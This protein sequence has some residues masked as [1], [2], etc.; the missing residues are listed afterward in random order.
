MFPSLCCGITA[1]LTAGLPHSF[2]FQLN[3]HQS[4][5]WQ[6]DTA[7]LFQLNLSRPSRGSCGHVLHIIQGSPGA[8][9]LVPCSAQLETS[10][11]W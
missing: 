6:P 1:A 7:A 9:T 10:R 11:L 3:L 4:Q 8:Y 2:I 5:L